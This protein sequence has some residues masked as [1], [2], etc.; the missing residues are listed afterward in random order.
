M[1]GVGPVG[2]RVD[3]LPVAACEVEQRVAG[4]AGASP[5]EHPRTGGDDAGGLRLE[6]R[7]AEV[8]PIDRHDG[9]GGGGHGVDQ[10]RGVESV[11]AGGDDDAGRDWSTGARA[12]VGRHRRVPGGHVP[13]NGGRVAGSHVDVDADCLAP[14]AALC[15]VETGAGDDH[16]SGRHDSSGGAAEWSRARAM[17]VRWIS[18]VPS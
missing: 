6:A 12:G 16:D 5:V 14:L 13:D 15:P 18:E 7:L 3:R 8:A 10:A 11:R 2:Q 4:R 17:I 1:A 9:Y